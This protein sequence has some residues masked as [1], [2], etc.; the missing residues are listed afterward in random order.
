MT[1]TVHG[2]GYSSVELVQVPEGIFANHQ[3]GADKDGQRVLLERVVVTF[4]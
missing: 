2:S 3:H 1:R 4:P